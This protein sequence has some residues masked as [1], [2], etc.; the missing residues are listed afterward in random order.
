M[1]GKGRGYTLIEMMVVLAIMSIMALA[2]IPSIRS[3]II[4]NRQSEGRLKLLEILQ[5]QRQFKALDASRSYTTNLA[6]LGYTG[7]SID[8]D[9]GVFSGD[10]E[11]V[12]KVFA[13]T[14]GSLTIV[15]CVALEARPI[16]V[17]TDDSTWVVSTDNAE[18]RVK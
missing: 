15:H 7:N 9:G 13:S 4:E 8:T 16:V 5:K 10:K 14:C 1:I 17:N 18:V 12:F 11:P 2:I 3:K 6:D